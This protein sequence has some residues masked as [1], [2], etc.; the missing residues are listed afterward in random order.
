MRL[1]TLPKAANAQV[2]CFLLDQNSHY[3]VRRV[4]GEGVGGQKNRLLGEQ[5]EQ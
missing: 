4:T 2:L 3:F 1:G 5:E